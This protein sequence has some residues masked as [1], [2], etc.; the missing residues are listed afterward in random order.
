MDYSHIC[1]T[2][3]FNLMMYEKKT[4]I[5]PNQIILGRALYETIAEY[6]NNVLRLD[7]KE[8]APSFYGIPVTIDEV[9]LQAVKLG[10]IS[11]L[12]NI[13]KNS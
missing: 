12:E 13:I 4:G 5:R 11:D 6:L 8:A 1:N 2:I 3:K 10:C 7:V 9:N